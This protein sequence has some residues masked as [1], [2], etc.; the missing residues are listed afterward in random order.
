MIFSGKEPL[1]EDELR[2]KTTFSERRVSVE[3]DLRWKT[4]FG[5]GQPLEDLACCLLQFAAFLLSYMKVRH[6]HRLFIW[7]KTLFI[8]GKGN[9]S[10]DILSH[11]LSKFGL[12]NKIVFPSVLLVQHSIQLAFG[13]S[14]SNNVIGH[15]F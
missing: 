10:L 11:N 9:R 3:D 14:T 15:Y 13:R 7:N 6:N 2:W 4:T 5:G 1:V 12:K 8:G